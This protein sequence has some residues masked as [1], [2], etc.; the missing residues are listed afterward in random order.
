M[1]RTLRT[2][3]YS[4]N[5]E[6]GNHILNALGHLPEVQVVAQATSLDEAL[7]ALGQE[8]LALFL[9]DLDPDVAASLEIVGHL[10]EQSHELGII[11]V[12]CQRDP[13]TIISAMRSGCTQFVCAPIE[14]EDLQVAL[15]RI[16]SAKPR[17]ERVCHRIGVIGSAG[18]AGTTMVACNLALE[19]AGLTESPTALLD[20][21][22]DFGDVAASFDTSPKY[23]VADVCSANAELDASV[24]ESAMVTLPCKVHLL[25]RPTKM[26]DANQVCPEAVSRMLD[27]LGDRYNNIVIDLPRTFTTGNAA[28]VQQADVLL[29]VAQLRVASIRNA[30]RVYE[31]LM[32]MG[33]DENAVKLV[34]NRAN[35][36]HERIS[37]GNVEETFGQP[38]FAKIPNDYRNVTAALDLGRPIQDGAPK[39]SARLAIQE[40]AKR[41]ATPQDSNSNAPKGL[42]QRFLGKKTAAN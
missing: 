30:H 28:V 34:L 29:I 6:T 24:I 15:A 21:D 19:L 9:V 16:A 3:V 31:L 26:G 32:H 13:E 8:R 42:F 20:M 36:A 11:G 35:A 39:S 25:A 22:L 37:A 27:I 1:A 18:G 5:A 10:A 23:T 2:C 33:A 41:I 17:G 14:I 7:A 38:I 40:L 12:S 4:A